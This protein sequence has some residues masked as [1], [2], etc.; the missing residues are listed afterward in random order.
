MRI[1]IA[2]SRTFDNYA[3]L[4]R[5]MDKLTFKLKK[6]IVLSGTADGADALGER[7]ALSKIGRVLM[8]Y[9]PDWEKHGKSAGAVRNAEMVANAE[10][11]VAFWDGKSPGTKDV[12]SKARKAKLKHIK[13]VKF[14]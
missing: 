5:T 8:R 1:I 4:E 12:I 2:G 3:L 11:L 6:V 14:K 9:H 7:W 13:V 10:A